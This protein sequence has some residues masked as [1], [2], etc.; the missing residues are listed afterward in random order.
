MSKRAAALCLLSLLA[1]GQT[2]RVEQ[3]RKELEQHRN[4][5]WAHFWLGVNLIE[6]KQWQEAANELREAM[7]GDLQPAWAEVWAHI[8]V[9]EILDIT[10]QHDRA[11]NEYRQAKRTK[12]DYARAQRFVDELLT[13]ASPITFRLLTDLDKIVPPKVIERVEP[14]YSDEARLVS[15][16]GTVQMVCEIGEDGSLRDVSIK[17]GLG[18]GLD[19]KAVEAVRKWKF[20]PG[21]FDGRPVAMKTTVEVEYS[22]ASGR[23]PRW[24]LG[25]AEFHPPEGASHPVITSAPFPAGNHLSPQ[26]E[27]WALRA[28]AARSFKATISFEI[29]EQGAPG[30]FGID[31]GTLP[32]FGEDAIAFLRGWRLTPGLKDRAA[33]AVPCKFDFVWG[34]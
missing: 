23:A 12:D 22:R 18:L 9:G 7:N 14:E 5:S 3:Y 26:A 16:E 13:Q 20:A 21:T 15:L 6:Q 28:P 17:Q 31:T 10:G 11:L 4:S 29:D 2:D 32:G 27:K 30:R 1:R 34:L 24:H 25:G 19:E 8:Y 33:I